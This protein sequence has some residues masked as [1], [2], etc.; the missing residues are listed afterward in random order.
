VDI[1]FHFI[2]GQLHKLEL[3]PGV[4]KT[5][6]ALAE[7]KAIGKREAERRQKITHDASGA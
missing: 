3:S 2:I 1:P 4:V 5:F 6:S 7:Q